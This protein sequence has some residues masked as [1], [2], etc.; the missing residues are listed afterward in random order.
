[1]DRSIFF[2]GVIK[3]IKIPIRREQHCLY[4]V[5]LCTYCIDSEK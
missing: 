5:T 4:V 3:T 1:M 2:F